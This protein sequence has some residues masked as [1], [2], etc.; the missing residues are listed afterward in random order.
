MTGILKVNVRAYEKRSSS[1][2]QITVHI[3]TPDMVG[4]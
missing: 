2:M 3:K 1:K 4:V